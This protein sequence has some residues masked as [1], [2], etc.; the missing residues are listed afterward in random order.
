MLLRSLAGMPLTYAHS[1][2]EP[3]V[4]TSERSQTCLAVAGSHELPLSSVQLKMLTGEVRV[5]KNTHI[6][7]SPR[8]FEIAEE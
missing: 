4:G 2:W 5:G 8:D 7:T 1:K 3:A 6:F